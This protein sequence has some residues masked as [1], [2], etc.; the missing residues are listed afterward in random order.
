MLP[1]ADTFL[2]AGDDGKVRL[3]DVRDKPPSNDEQKA[4]YDSRSIVGKQ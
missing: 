1:S 4:A 3:F 2:S